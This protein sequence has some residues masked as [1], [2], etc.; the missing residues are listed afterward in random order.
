M[1]LSFYLFEREN[2]KGGR[3]GGGEGE[4]EGRKVQRSGG[5]KGRRREE[6]SGRLGA[7][8]TPASSLTAPTPFREY[9]SNKSEPRARDSNPG[10]ITWDACRST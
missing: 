6:R 2:T 10:T 3:E 4:E 7:T 9:I 1:F 5:R 8:F